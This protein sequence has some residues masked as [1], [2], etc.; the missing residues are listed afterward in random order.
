MFTHHVYSATLLLNPKLVAIDRVRYDIITHKHT[1]LF[2]DSFSFLT[3]HWIIS[4][5]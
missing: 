3:W 4:I 5:I 2:G 1:S